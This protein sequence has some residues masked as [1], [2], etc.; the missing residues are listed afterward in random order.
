MIRLQLC[1]EWVSNGRNSL[2]GQKVKKLNWL[3]IMSYGFYF[4]VALQPNVRYGLLILGVSRL[5]TTH[6]SR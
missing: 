3:R 6:H 5:H 4:S 1:N 2:K